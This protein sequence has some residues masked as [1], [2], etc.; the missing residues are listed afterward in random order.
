M[1]TRFPAGI[2]NADNMSTLS[3][4]PA[5][6]PSKLYGVFDDFMGTLSTLT[7]TVVETQA[8][9][10]QAQAAGGGG[11]VLLTNS[12]AIGD[13]NALATPLASYRIVPG[14]RFY[15][16]MRALVSDVTNVI[17]HMGFEVSSATL[18]P[19]NG[20]YVT[21]TGTS[22][23]LTNAN[24]STLTTAVFADASGLLLNEFCTLGIEYDG[25]NVNVYYGSDA[26]AG[27]LPDR[28]VASIETPNFNTGVDLLFV[29]GM[30]NVN[31]VANTAT[32]DYAFGAMER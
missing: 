15:A 9:A 3:N 21:K 19:A 30:K 11:R 8:G 17:L 24:A 2:N 14:K 25:K 28:K 27:P 18:L 26:A 22:I 6:D 29:V 20:V 1:T 31:A 4:M 23:V 13:V 10:T 32:L 12:A 16:K 5:M 7:W